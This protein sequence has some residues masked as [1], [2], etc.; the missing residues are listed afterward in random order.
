MRTIEAYSVPV[1]NASSPSIFIVI[2]LL[3]VQMVLTG[4]GSL[5]SGYK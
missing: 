4:F 3:V 1:A 2:P 5:N